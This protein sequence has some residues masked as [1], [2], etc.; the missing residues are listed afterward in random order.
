MVFGLVISGFE[1]IRNIEGLKTDSASRP[2][3]DVRV[4]DCGQLFTKSANDGEKGGGILFI[5][6]CLQVHH[7]AAVVIFFIGCVYSL[8]IAETLQLLG[9]Q[10][11]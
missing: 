10:Y 2:Y 5:C 9:I 6:Y 1:V 7:T 4:I 3:A 8:D 11:N